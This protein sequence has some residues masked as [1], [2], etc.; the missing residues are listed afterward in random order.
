MHDLLD[1][2]RPPV[3]GSVCRGWTSVAAC[4]LFKVHDNR[5]VSSVP[6]PFGVPVDGRLSPSGSVAGVPTMEV[7]RPSSLLGV[8]VDRNVSSPCSLSG[9]PVV[10]FV[11]SAVPCLVCL[12]LRVSRPLF[13]VRCASCWR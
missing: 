13:L 1:V 11:S 8:P 2:C 4:S 9:V 12:L 5:G 3:P 10:D 7:Y 6:L